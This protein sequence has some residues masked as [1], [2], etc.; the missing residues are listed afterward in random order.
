MGSF[1]EDKIICPFWRLEPMIVQ[2]VA[3]RYTAYD[4][5]I[6]LQWEGLQNNFYDLDTV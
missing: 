2:P 4:I 3:S 6:S 1:G 5:P